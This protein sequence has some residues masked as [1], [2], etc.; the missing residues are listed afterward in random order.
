[1]GPNVVMVVKIHICRPKSCLAS[2]QRSVHGVT[3]VPLWFAKVHRRKEM[4]TLNDM[5]LGFP[6]ITAKP[7]V[8]ARQKNRF[9]AQPLHLPRARLYSQCTDGWCSCGSCTSNNLLREYH[10]KP[11]FADRGLQ[12]PRIVSNGRRYLRGSF[13]LL[14]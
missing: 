10:D 9:S 14:R 8:L 6:P 1:M 2:L 13:P 5:C 12:L 11:P 3:G 7:L 4:P